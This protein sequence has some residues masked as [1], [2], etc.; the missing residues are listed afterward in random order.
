MRA[1]Q[2][3][4]LDY[5]GNPDNLPTAEFARR[6]RDEGVDVFALNVPGV[7]LFAPVPDRSRQ[8]A[9]ADRIRAEIDVAAGI[10]AE[11]VQIYP[12]TARTG[13][14]GDA[15]QLAAE[16]LR[17]VAEYAARAGITLGVENT[18]DRSGETPDRRLNPSM[19]PE[20]LH[21]IVSAVDSCALKACFDPTNWYTSGIEPFPYAYDVLK[22]SVVNVQLKDARRFRPFGDRDEP[23]A[24]YL[25]RNEPGRIGPSFTADGDG[26]FLP[27]PLGDGAV[28]WW[29]LAQ[30]LIAGGYGGWWTLDPYCAPDFVDTW[31]DRS[32]DYWFSTLDRHDDA[33][34]VRVRD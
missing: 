7:S 27:V 16:Q 4:A 3:P 34:A 6:L 18:N 28:N 15:V 25:V 31:I 22:D 11:F 14:Y 13:R 1:W 21:D 20:L 30:R 32:L 19:L 29:G 2:I 26:D 9:V 8:R 17:P 23:N 10:G 24:S 33:E 12:A 5:W